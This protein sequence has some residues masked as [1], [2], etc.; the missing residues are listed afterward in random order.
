MCMLE[1]HEVIEFE[2]ARGN[3][4]PRNCDFWMP[5][6]SPMSREPGKPCLRSPESLKWKEIWSMIV[7]WL[8]FILV[9]RK[10]LNKPSLI[11]DHHSSRCYC[12]VPFHGEPLNCFFC[13]STTQCRHKPARLDLKSIVFPLRTIHRVLSL[14]HAVLKVPPKQKLNTKQSEILLSNQ[15]GCESFQC[16]FHCTQ[17]NSSKQV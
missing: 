11:Q 6:G 12:F 7:K 9:R 10:L 3:L 8:S 16:L 14:T 1:K 5:T 17:Q 2:D 4:P 13:I 15:D